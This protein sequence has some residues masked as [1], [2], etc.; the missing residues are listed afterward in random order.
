VAAV[1]WWHRAQCRG[2]DP[3][4]FFPTKD[5][6]ESLREAKALCRGCPVTDE[7]LTDAVLSG[8][9]EGVRA[10]LSGRERRKLLTS[11]KQPDVAKV[12]IQCGAGFVGFVQST[13]CSDTCRRDRVRARDRDRVR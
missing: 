7:C 13:L 2:L 6:P 4:L 5:D 12:C 8:D 3:D 1:N 10:G 9:S 11:V